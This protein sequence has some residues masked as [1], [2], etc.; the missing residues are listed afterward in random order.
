MS[1]CFACVCLLCRFVYL[2]TCGNCVAKLLNSCLFLRLDETCPRFIDFF[3]VLFSTVQDLC[4]LQK[5]LP[6]FAT[7]LEPISKYR[8][9]SCN[10]LNES[11]INFS[12]KFQFWICS[13]NP[14]SL[15]LRVF[16]MGRFMFQTLENNNF[17]LCYFAS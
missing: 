11:T 14:V 6:L 7:C 10:N 9:F 15:L 13:N 4:L 1:F 17:A 8:I 2:I 5:L 16:F 3:C 12:I